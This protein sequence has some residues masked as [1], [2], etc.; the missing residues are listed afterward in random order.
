MALRADSEAQLLALL[1]EGYDESGGSKYATTLMD[2]SG[3]VQSILQA[4]NRAQAKAG[5]VMVSAMMLQRR[6]R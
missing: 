5:D 3:R 6:T 1:L 2:V 4:R